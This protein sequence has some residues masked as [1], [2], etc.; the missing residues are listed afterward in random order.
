MLISCILLLGGLAA[1]SGLIAYVSG[2]EQEDQKICVIDAASG[3]SQAIG[4]GDRDGAPAWSPDG[5]LIAYQS[6]GGEEGLGIYLVSSKGEDTRRISHLYPWCHDPRWST[7]GCG[8]A[9][10]KAGICGRYVIYTGEEGDAL[11]SHIVLF[12]TQ[13]KSETVWGGGTEGLMQASWLPNLQLTQAL[14]AEDIVWEGV[15]TSAFIRELNESGCLLAVGVTKS[16]T[17][18]STELFLV[19]Q[20]QAVPLL[21]LVPTMKATS[22]RYEEWNIR[23]DRKARRIV[24][25]SN[26]GGNREIFVLHKKGLTN[27][28]NHRTADWDPV[29]SPNGEW[30]AFVGF[31]EGPSGVYRVF[32]DTALVQPVDASPQYRSWHPA[33]APDSEWLVYVS[34]ATGDP[35]LY[36]SRSNGEERRQLTQHPGIDDAPAWRPEVQ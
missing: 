24:F 2:V 28:T 29:W 32:P 15:D 25:E 1:P 14:H 36:L 33:W 16:P 10:C 22:R 31:R 23:P 8:Q 9:V 27:V 19:S 26:D 34:D 35:E 5:T 30:L 6:K 7:D 4:L 11:K 17:G 18:L 13:A 3:Q 21:P 12:D 20:S